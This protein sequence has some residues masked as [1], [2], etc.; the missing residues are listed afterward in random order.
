M[1]YEA[2]LSKVPARQ[3]NVHRVKAEIG[4]PGLVAKEYER[5]IRRI[6]H[7]GP[8]EFPRFD[9]ILLGMGADGHTASLFPGSALLEETER[10]VVAGWVE[11]MRSW[12]VSMTAPLIN[13]AACV[14]VLVA[15]AEKA[16][17]LHQALHGPYEPSRLP[18]QLIEPR[19]GQLIWLVDREAAGGL[20]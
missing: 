5:E 15:G 11:S 9:M 8:L 18:I 19:D 10:F 12:R 2:L 3:E 17:A 14:I 16:S 1:A 6:F 13:N 20:A 7:P 4:D